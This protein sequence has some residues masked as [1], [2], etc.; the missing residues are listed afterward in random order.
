MFTLYYCVGPELCGQTCVYLATGKAKELRGRYINSERD[1]ETVVNQ[2]DIVKKENLYDLGI[3]E[4]GA[5]GE[6]DAVSSR[7]KDLLEG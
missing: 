7:L 6:G 2:A 1:I 4:L 3:R 5:V